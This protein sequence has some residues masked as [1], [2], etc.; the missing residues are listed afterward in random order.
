MQELCSAYARAGGCM[1]GCRAPLGPTPHRGGKRGGSPRLTI[2]TATFTKIIPLRLP[3]SAKR[4]DE[5]FTGTPRAP[6][7]ILPE[8]S[9]GLRVCIILSPDLDPAEVGSPLET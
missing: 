5:L 9:G 2:F 4:C 6:S 8:G 3:G 1:W 7:I